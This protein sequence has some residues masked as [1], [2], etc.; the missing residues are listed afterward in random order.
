MSADANGDRRTT[1]AKY[2]RRLFTRRNYE[3]S[4]TSAS[5]G[6]NSTRLKCGTGRRRNQTIELLRCRGDHD[7]PLVARAPLERND[8]ADSDL[9][10]WVTSQAE[11]G[12]CGIS[13]H[14]TGTYG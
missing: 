13:D 11:Y 7:K 10:A 3:G 4:S 6:T 1:A 14:A 5:L 9:I 8:T 12:F 2:W